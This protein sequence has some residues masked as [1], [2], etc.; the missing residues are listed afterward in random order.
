MY[1][2]HE[3]GIRLNGQLIST[4]IPSYVEEAYKDPAFLSSLQACEDA[5]Y[6]PCLAGDAWL[7]R[8]GYLAPPLPIVTRPWW[9]RLLDA[10][11]MS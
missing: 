1:S 4:P 10:L 11:T 5:G 7:A 6:P 2:W 8:N 9:R 3:D